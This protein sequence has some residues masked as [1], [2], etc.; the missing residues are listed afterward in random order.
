M[1]ELTEISGMNHNTPQASKSD[2]AL[3]VKRR[4][5][6]VHRA[7]EKGLLFSASE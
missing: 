1:S 4:A 2:R 6:D 3:D 5:V 7:Y